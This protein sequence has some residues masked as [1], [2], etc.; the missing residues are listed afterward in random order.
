VKPQFEVGRGKVGRGGVV[1]DA[2][3]HRAVLVAVAE[4]VRRS[5]WCLL[6]VLRC[7]LPG[8][9]GNVEFFVHLARRGNGLDPAAAAS[10]IDDAASPPRRD[11]AE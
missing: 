11:G 3:L 1:R 4:S 9:E 10:R 8:A 5:G 7:P 6:D 2:G